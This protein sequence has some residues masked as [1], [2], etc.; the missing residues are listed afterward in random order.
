M[1]RAASY[2]GHRAA[3]SYI[4]T[5]EQETARWVATTAN[6]YLRESA[7]NPEMDECCRAWMEMR[8]YVVT[9]GGAR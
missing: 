5:A 1:S 4:G 2:P 9:K 8:G 3:P 6:A 7:N